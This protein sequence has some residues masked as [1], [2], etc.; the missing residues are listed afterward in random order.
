ML[1]LLLLICLM[2]TSACGDNI[3]AS[4]AIR[5]VPDPK[6]NALANADNYKPRFVR[7]PLFR[8]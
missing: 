1:F 5:T 8:P 6:F 4:P 7:V 2:A 3:V